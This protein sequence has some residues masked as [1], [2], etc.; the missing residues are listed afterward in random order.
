MC[1]SC[2]SSNQTEY[3]AEMLVHFGGLK[4][5]DKPSV[6]VYPSLLVCMECGFTQA[7]IPASALAELAAGAVTSESPM[8]SASV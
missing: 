6:W 1:S 2:G 7:T 4:N 8:R 3:T 5:L